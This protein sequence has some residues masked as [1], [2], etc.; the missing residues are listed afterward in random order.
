[1]VNE[2][3]TLE[4]F[5]EDIEP[6]FY[7]KRLT[8]VDV[9]AYTG[10]VY[11]AFQAKLKIK[12]AHLIEPNLENLN[13]LKSMVEEVNNKNIHIHNIAI[14]NEK[15][16]IKIKNNKSMS[17]VISE[18][19]VDYGDYI[20]IESHPLDELI[21]TI[22]E[23][24]IS[25][26]KIDVEGFEKEVLEGSNTILNNQQVDLLYIETG[27][28]P[29]NNHQTNYRDIDDIMLQKG[30]R[31]FR[32]YEQMFEWMEDSPFLRRVNLAYMSTKFAEQNPFRLANELFEKKIYISSLQA[33][34]K[35]I[36]NEYQSL[37]AEN[38]NTINAQEKEIRQLN[39][40]IKKIHNSLVFKLRQTLRKNSDSIT[41]WIKMPFSLL[42]TII[43][44]KK[45]KELKTFAYPEPIM[46]AIIWQANNLM[47]QGDINEGVIFAEKYAKDTQKNAIGFLKANR[48]IANE[49]KWLKHIN[50]YIK[51][52]NIEPIKLSPN[53]KTKFHRI[54]AECN[55]EI[56]DGPLVTVI[57]PAY[58]A[59]N[60][61]GHSVDSILNQT[62]ENIELIIID[63]CSSDNTW[64]LLEKLSKKD[65]RITLLKNIV[66][67]GPYVSKNYALDISNGDYVTGHDADDWAHPQRIEK[68]IASMLKNSKV[69]ACVA[70][71]V[72]MTLEG[73]IVGFH[74]ATSEQDDSIL[75]KAFISCMFESSFLKNNIGYWDSV[76]FG[77]DSEIMNRIKSYDNHAYK[78]VDIFS[79][80]CLEV[81]SSLTNHPEFGIS[82][83][84][85]LSPARK[86]YLQQYKL[87]HSNLKQ[88]NIY[89]K[90]PL[91]KRPF[92]VNK[93]SVVSYD[94]IMKNLKKVRN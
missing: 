5:I 48:D 90:F 30:Y 88:D 80:I 87:W 34:N 66:N 24:H 41:G 94:D 7:G 86:F 55:Y 33:E 60:Y 15:K 72:R 45:T 54:Y 63:D 13:V 77:A 52:F 62:W 3:G 44:W 17:K 20:E 27:I 67:V 53:G 49:K 29:S 26:L 70:K 14:G 75:G 21:E 57:M 40:Q 78:E 92:N 43:E 22:T 42:K 89:M 32:I 37:Q 51:Q 81:Q 56:T 84:T 69:K 91:Q 38:K 83:T 10:E 73:K 50:D 93:L 35:K 11:K 6:F 31:L 4:E 68:Q 23:N 47:E 59:Q 64:S 36:I 58:N 79:M 25:I 28:D 74:K 39:N 71:K 19:S 76:R 61:I 12:E 46:N 65:N 2:R 18:K 9:G 85:G 8:Y 16:T 82:K 1:M